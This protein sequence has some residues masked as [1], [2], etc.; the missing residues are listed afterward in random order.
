MF[1]LQNRNIRENMPFKGSEF[2]T[3]NLLAKGRVFR[4]CLF[5]KFLYQTEN[6]LKESSKFYVL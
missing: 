4:E 1:R 3:S 5:A 2:R 6:N